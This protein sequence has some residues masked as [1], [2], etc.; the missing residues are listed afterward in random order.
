MSYPLGEFAPVER[1]KSI[2]DRGVGCHEALARGPHSR[3][4]GS[5][6]APE[7]SFIFEG[8]I[9]SE[10]AGFRLGNHA[11]RE[12]SRRRSRNC[13]SHSSRKRSTSA[14]DGWPHPSE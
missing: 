8:R 9:Q 5:Q 2:G 7:E 3:E 12:S 6:A 4:N 13:A 10:S 1:K 11:G 14:S